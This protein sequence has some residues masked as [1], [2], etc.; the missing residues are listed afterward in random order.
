MKK[1][2][3]VSLVMLLAVSVAFS[4]FGIKGGI[5]LATFRGDDKTMDAGNNIK[6]DPKTRLGLVGGI[7]AKIGLIAGLSIQPEAMYVQKGAVYENS[8]NYGGY[9]YT[10]KQTIKGDYVEF[11]LL[12]KFNLPIPEFSPYIEGGASYGILLSAKSKEEQSSNAPGFTSTSNETDIKDQVTKND[13]SFIVGVGFDIFILDLNARYV[14]GTKR[15]GKDDP[16]T[17]EDENAKKVY[18]SGIMITAGLRF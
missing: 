17:P 2:L 6:L 1:I 5:N 10:G 18:S 16:N 3:L 11:P 4:Q 8:G 13:L 14:I 12:L 9:S 7:S 15:L